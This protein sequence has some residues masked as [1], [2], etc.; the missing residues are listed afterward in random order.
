MRE[1][2]AAAQLRFS[3]GRGCAGATPV[4]QLPG[5]PAGRDGNEVSVNQKL[6]CHTSDA[7]AYNLILGINEKDPAMQ[8]LAFRRLTAQ[9]A[10]LSSGADAEATLSG[11]ESMTQPFCSRRPGD[12]IA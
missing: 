9:P 5:S 11:I 10:A 6:R 8:G 3:S 4:V 7:S 12:G 1:Q 2:P